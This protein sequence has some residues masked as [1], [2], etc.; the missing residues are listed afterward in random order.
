[1]SEKT[2]MDDLMAMTPDPKDK[3]RTKT[4]RLRALMPGIEAALER[5][6]SRAD[7]VKK[8]NA[9]GFEIGMATFQ[10]SIQRIRKKKKSERPMKPIQPASSQQQI[11]TSSIN[12]N[13]ARGMSPINAA[14]EE[15]RQQ[16]EVDYSKIMRDHLKSQKNKK[17]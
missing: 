15:M 5:G 10:T 4:A 13:L 1:M 7:I 6:N 12:E 8:L 14:L 2:L 17:S 16:P 11:I 9:E 3:T